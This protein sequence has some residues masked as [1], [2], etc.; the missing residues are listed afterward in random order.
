MAMCLNLL[1][2]LVLCFAK[3]YAEISNSYLAIFADIALFL[4]LFVSMLIKV[5]IHTVLN[6]AKVIDCAPR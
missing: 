5:R 3:P 1:H 2:L 4:T 6:R